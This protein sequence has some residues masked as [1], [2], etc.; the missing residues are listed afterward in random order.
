MDASTRRSF[1]PRALALALI[2]CA[3][4]ASGLVFV[5][6][7]AAATS[8][9]EP[10]GSAEGPLTG[11]T[12]VET[13]RGAPSPQPEFNPPPSETPSSGGPSSPPPPAPPATP[14]TGG[15]ALA[16]NR[17]SVRG[18]VALVSLNCL[19]TQ[20][21]RGKLTLTPKNSLKPKHAKRNKPHAVT[22]GTVSVSIPGDEAK[23]VKIDLDAA[24]RA[25]L[26]AG[27]GHLSASLAI[28]ELAPS[29]KNTQ[30]KTVHLVQQKARAKTEK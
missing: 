13:C 9:S 14:T 24:G 29:P 23:T 5:S 25:L 30:I 2:S 21:C 18:P 7:V 22:I 20:S 19:G 12:S 3:V 28:L 6:T 15:L 27:H 10:S 11:C 26:K 4:L 1:P 16:A 8:G 17:V